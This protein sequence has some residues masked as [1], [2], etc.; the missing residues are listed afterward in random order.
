M[1]EHTQS[2]G[3]EEGRAFD[4]NDVPPDEAARE[5]G[6][7]AVDLHTDPLAPPDDGVG[8]EALVRQWRVAKSLEHLRSQI[9][10][11]FPQRVKTS[12]GM[13]GDAAHASRT[14]DH[15]PWVIDDG[16][17]VVTA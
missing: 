12:D 10:A 9:N 11:A 3:D 13:I 1:T 16:I 17:G 2:K 7:D 14:S 8:L 6:P 5:L 15:N 4:L